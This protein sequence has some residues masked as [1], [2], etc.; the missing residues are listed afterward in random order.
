MMLLP[1]LLPASVPARRAGLHE[2]L[3][4]RRTTS[5]P[6]TMSPGGQAVQLHKVCWLKL[7]GMWRGARGLGLALS[8]RGQLR[9]PSRCACPK[10][11]LQTGNLSHNTLAATA[12]S[13][14]LETQ[15]PR[16]VIP[17][18]R[19]PTNVP[20][21]LAPAHRSVCA[22]RI[23]PLLHCVCAPSQA[24]CAVQQCS[25]TPCAGGAGG[26]VLD[27][28]ASRGRGSPLLPT[29]FDT[30]T[31][32]VTHPLLIVPSSDAHCSHACAGVPPGTY[33]IVWRMKV[34]QLIWCVRA[35]ESERASVCAT[36]SVWACSCV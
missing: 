35:C 18:P 26:E 32:C 31:L 27:R 36:V 14:I 23:L 19:N 9:Q 12:S 5:I 10:R 16:T 21:C 15:K 7:T 25:C 6:G 4:L 34:L 20:D 8:H 3:Y 1:N 11:R 28:S 29:H 30:H 2:P 22:P 24:P 33:A 17:R 13:R